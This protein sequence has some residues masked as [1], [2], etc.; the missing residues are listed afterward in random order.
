MRPRIS[1]PAATFVRVLGAFGT[2]GFTY[3]DLITHAK[4]LLKDGASPTELL[5]VLQHFE[6]VEPLPQDA[7]AEVV[8]L[9]TDAI[10]RAGPQSEGPDTASSQAPATESASP[11]DEEVNIDF[12]HM[13]DLGEDSLPESK[14]AG[15]YSSEGRSAWAST[16]SVLSEFVRPPTVEESSAAGRVRALEDQIARQNAAHDALA[17]S[18]ERARDG[19]SAAV[20]RTTALTSE[21]AAARTILELQQKKTRDAEKALAERAATAEAASSRGE[22]ALREARRQQTE[23]RALRDSLAA[24]DKSLVQSRHSLDEREAQLEALQREHAD[25]VSAVDARAKAWVQQEADLQAAFSALE[26]EQHKNRDLNKALADKVAAA[27]AADARS[28]E[29]LRET[30][31]NQTESRTLRDLL[32]ARDATLGQVRRSLGERETQ[33][34]ALQQEHVKMQRASEAGAKTGTRLETDLQ[35][36]RARADAMSSDLK[37]ARGAAAELSAQLKR[38]ADQ[39]N[40]ALSELRDLKATESS[41]LESLRTRD[42]RNGFGQNMV[43]EL[44]ARVDAAGV[45]QRALVVERERLQAQVADLQRKLDAHEILVAELRTAN[46][47]AQQVADLHAAT[48]RQESAPPA[49]IPPPRESAPLRESS[50]VRESVAVRE[51]EKAVKLTPPPRPARKPVARVAWD[52]R[53][54]IRAMGVGIAMIVLVAV[55]WVVVHQKPVPPPAPVAAVPVLP[56]PGTVIRDCPTCPA[57]TV[58]PVGR[59]RQG[60][61]S[62]EAGSESF[63]KPA[64]GVVISR[65]FAMAT[66]AVTVDQFQE[67]IAA[68]GVDMQGCDTYDRDWKHRAKNSWKDPGFVQS[69]THPVTCVSWNDAKAYASWLSAKTGHGYRLPSAS[70][71]EYAARTGGEA[72]QPWNPDGSDACTNAN[73][74]DASAAH[75]YPGWSVFA[76]DDGYVNTAPVGSFKTNAWGL[77]DMLGNVFQWTE[78]CWSPD[79]TDAP[80]DGSARADGDCTEHELRGGSWF[81]TPAYVKAN[82]RNHFA[83]DYRTSSVGIRLV[84]DIQQ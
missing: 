15:D 28:E 79:Y 26:S 54:V 4:L 9:L 68:T 78:D 34:A 13:N 84:R 24:R 53:A 64:H 8:G 76:C 27:E 16:S 42:W 58:L 48:Q 39:L 77:N 37:A 11:A 55:A 32:S 31:R 80:A 41:K 45:G 30:E 62:P 72:V 57:M 69:G 44:D 17:R 70:E 12:D 46:S 7:H 2:G 83:A 20:A 25:I 71:W 35:S 75:R 43:R 49:E 66:N 29:A 63:A 61:V 22:E 19:E 36:S 60:S 33:L 51:S 23:L 21:L 73:V 5:E 6:L 47:E 14:D 82:Y 1:S 74:A 67:F 3:A 52:R 81:S 50:P 59:F 38:T 65:P 40:A 18:Y 10:E 56:K